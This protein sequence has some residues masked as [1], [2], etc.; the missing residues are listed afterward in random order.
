M[1]NI[2]IITPAFGAVI[3][4]I[5]NICFEN[6]I[7]T[8]LVFAIFI[9]LLLFPFGI[10]QQK[11]SI[12]QAKL[13]PMETVIRKKYAGRNDR[14][15]QQKLNQEI[16]ELYQSENFNPASG[17]LPLLIQMPILFGLYGVI[18]NPL[19]Y[20]SGLGKDIV[21]VL[22][23][24]FGT[25]S[26]YDI[27]VIKAIT[28]MGEAVKPAVI[29]KIDAQFAIQGIEAEASQVI[30]QITD[31]TGNFSI[32]GIDLTVNPTV[33]L[34]L[35]MIIPILT[36][37]FAFLS[38]KIIRKYT[39]QPQQTQEAQSSM[40]MMEWTMPLLSVW[41]SFSVPAAIAIYWM[42]QNV[43]SAAQQIALHKMYPIPPVTDEQIK[44]AELKYK[45]KS[46]NK[47]KK[48]TLPE[49]DY[50]SPIYE[51]VPEVELEEKNLEVNDRP[52]GLTPK[53]KKHL[54]ETGKPLKA[55]RKI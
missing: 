25:A 8:L 16:M 13:R 36:F 39:Y 53:I 10:K 42:I 55:R 31:L 12:K 46:A 47:A 2:P 28:D 21:D 14:A 34:N 32:F 19:R 17:C 1:T 15:T 27:N 43:L 9:K 7:V 24:V 52:L 51:E 38:Q 6:Y 11:N 23:K 20:I 40:A 30:K 44:E 4:W 41:I 33:G 54:K 49:P 18:V 5:Y 29:S 26:N 45:G 35:Y 48:A 50:N 37:V 22:A 3:G